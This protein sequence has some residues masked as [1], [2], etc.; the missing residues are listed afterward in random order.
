MRTIKKSDVIFNLDTK[1]VYVRDFNAKFF[2]V[3]EKDY[4]IEYSSADVVTTEKEGEIIYSLNLDWKRLRNVGKGV[5]VFK[6]INNIP[7]EDFTDGS[8][9][10]EYKITTDY[11]ID[12]FEVEPAEH[13]SIVELIEE[14]TENRIS[15]DTFLSGA[16]DAVDA[17]VDAKQ[18]IL[19]SG[20]NIKTINNES[21]LGEGNIE[22][23]STRY[24]AG[25]GIDI[26]DDV[27]SVTGK[28]DSDEY[29]AF[30]VDTK[31]HMTTEIADRTAA[32][33][34]LSAAV[35]TLD[36]KVEDYKHATNTAVTA[37]GNALQGEVAAR[38]AND[39][40]LSAR[41]GTGFSSSSITDVIIENEEI[42]SSALNDLDEKKLD[43]SA[44]TPTDLSNYYTK[45]ETSGKTEIQTA[46][47]LKVNVA[48]VVTAI[49]PSNSGSTDPVATCVVAENEEVVAN[50]LTDLDA[51]KQ[52]TLVSGTN[53]K[54]IN[55]ESILGSGNIDIQGGGSN[56][57]SLTQAEYDALETIDPDALYVISDAAEVDMS[58]YYTKAQTNTI[59]GD[60]QDTLV[61]G[62]NIKT[63]NNESILGE[64]NIDIQGGSNYTAGEGIDITNDVISVT[65]KVDT[66]YVENVEKTVARAMN[67]LN[68]R[69]TANT[70]ALGGL[71]LVKLT[72]AEYDALATKDPNTLYIIDNSKPT[73]DYSN[74][75]LTFVVTTGGNIK[76]SGST[77]ENTLSYSK[78]NGDTWNTADSATTIPVAEG[79]K[80]LWKGTP[81]PQTSKGI[82]KF[83]GDTAARYSIEGNAMSLLFGDDFKNQTSIGSYALISL[84]GSNP[85]ITGAENMVLPATTLAYGSYYGM[86]YGCTSL[87]TAPSIL[88]ATTLAESC[89]GAM[90]R[91]CTSLTTAPELPTTTLAFRCYDFMFFGCTSLTTA[92]ELPATTLANECYNGMFRVCTSL[93]TAPELPATTLAERCYD[94]M[95]QGCRS[96]TSITCLATDIS[97]SGCTTDWVN[98]VAASGTFTKAAS[99]TSWTEGTSGIPSGWTVIDKE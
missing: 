19:I 81:T 69:T 97:A 90:F 52:D 67:D 86:F 7:D 26:S 49:T 68:E 16:I 50:A 71:S 41:V 75:Y 28:V 88:P 47:G 46:L 98:G 73:H 31:N 95:F 24:T 79:D 76:F 10:S 66:S 57:I 92:P 82:G 51:R 65:G 1:H 8:Y 99:M 38:T 60:K 48:D 44:Y 40:D 22:I 4:S 63:I 74:D 84:F 21:V 27:I 12:T 77:A 25:S 62:T 61:S 93:T 85:N 15:G 94:N 33:G 17:K 9:N 87:T 78:D 54:T 45:S 13:E 42:V 18:D 70:T 64:G 39:A 55:N 6:C 53:I 36:A 11:F 83:S 30:T 34:V 32:D 43:A 29:L 80:V 3:N 96:L 89:Y 91:G 72:Q 20:T 37:L 2:T 58:N 5:L 14:E 35:D 59:V 23:E 56:V